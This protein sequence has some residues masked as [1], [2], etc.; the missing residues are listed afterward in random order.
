MI[1]VRRPPGAALMVAAAASWGLSAVLTKVSLQQLAPLDLFGIELTAAAALIWA[2][3]LLRGLP[4]LPAGWRTFAALGAVEPALAFA[5]F[6]LGLSRTGAADGA[7]LLATE[8]LFTVLLGRLVLGERMS[9][10]TTAAV[11]LGFAGA[12]LV[13]LGTTGHAVARSGMPWSSAAQQRPPSST[14]GQESSPKASDP[15]RSPPCSC[16]RRLH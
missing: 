13:A 14:S 8:S 3:V 9:G 4:G 16:S 2:G 12:V 15:S 5:L 6:N 7:I 11:P 1:A 10:R